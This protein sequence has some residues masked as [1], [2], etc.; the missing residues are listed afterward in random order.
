[1]TF[2]IELRVFPLK[3]YWLNYLDI[4]SGTLSTMRLFVHYIFHIPQLTLSPPL[5]HCIIMFVNYLLI[6]VIDLTNKLT[7]L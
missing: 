4:C 3:V 5:V 1:M 7:M 2:I 6:A